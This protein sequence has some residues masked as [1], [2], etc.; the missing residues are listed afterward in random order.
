ML[1]STTQS[2]LLLVFLRL[3]KSTLLLLFRS[4]L[5]FLGLGIFILIFYLQFEGDFSFLEISFVE[6]CSW[7]VFFYLFLRHYLLCRDAQLG[8]IWSLYLLFKNVGWLMAFIVTIV[9][10]GLFY[11]SD[12]SAISY[13]SDSILYQYEHL[14]DVVCMVILFLCV[15]FSAPEIETKSES[16]LDGSIP[17][18]E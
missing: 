17:I 13:E 10:V 14:I 1:E 3:L 16:T 11:S 2:N 5:L 7:G 6:L 18:S 4:S 9:V 15:Y 8:R 12:P